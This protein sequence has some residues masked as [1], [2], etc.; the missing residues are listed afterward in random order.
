MLFKIMLNFCFFLVC[1]Q[2]VSYAGTI[3]PN[4]PQNKYTEYA[5]SFS[6]VGKLCGSYKDGS[7]FCA[8][9]VA[10][11]DN[12]ILTAAHVVENAKECYIHINNKQILIEK[13]IVNKDFK[14][15]DV[16]I[17]D[18]AIGLCKTKIDLDSYPELYTEDPIGKLCSISGFG[19][20]GTF[21]T[22]A[23]KSDNKQRAGLNFTEELYKNTIVCDISKPGEKNYT[24]LEF[25][26]AS[27]DS[28]GGLFID[29]KLAGINSFV[30]TTDGNPNS[31]YRD[32]SH[33][34]NIS[35]YI[36]WIKLNLS[37]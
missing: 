15:N 18:I 34:T 5:K 10:I 6:C 24:E 22:G 37:N 28:G 1:S 29:G 16:G 27:G 20:T 26:I 19:I 4:I 8:S 30:S 25:L 3:D 12:V 9:A 23:V 33:H 13:F 35:I 36:E 2:I 7:K 17:G 21:L 14:F 31:S 11:S 32:E